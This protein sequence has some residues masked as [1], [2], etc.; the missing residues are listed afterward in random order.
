MRNILFALMA[1]VSLLFAYSENFNSYKSGTDLHALDAQGITF[2]SSGAWEVFAMPFSVFHSPV[3]LEPGTKSDNTPLTLRFDKTQCSITFDIATDGNDRV[4]VSGTYAAQEVYARTIDL[5]AQSDLYTG[6]IA[7]NTKIDSVTIE[8]VEGKRALLDNIETTACDLNSYNIDE[9]LIAHFEFDDSNTTSGIIKGAE[10][11]AQNERDLKSGFP[12]SDAKTIAFWYRPTTQYFGSIITTASLALKANATQLVTDDATLATLSAS[13]W[14]H[15]VLVEANEAVALFIDGE[16]ISSYLT[17]ST[18]YVADNALI[19]GDDSAALDSSAAID[20]LR[21]Y[22]RTLSSSEIQELY[23]GRAAFSDTF[24][25]GKQYCIDNPKACGL[26][27]IPTVTATSLAQDI[28]SLAENAFAFTWYMW[29]TDEGDIYLTDG[30]ANAPRVWKM[31]AGT[32]QWKPIHNAEAF[33]G[34]EA[35]GQNFKYVEIMPDGSGII[36]GSAASE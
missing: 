12:S 35:Q 19:I 11:L 28:Q 30:N 8:T 9:G 25:A 32:K 26:Q 23:Y 15:I 18:L 36:F 14:H 22:S 10:T 17:S 20:D 6:S 13:Q 7:I 21:L 33:D 2:S 24:E 4:K 5:T 31:V 34:F 16:A 29:I 27:A 1:S 3:L